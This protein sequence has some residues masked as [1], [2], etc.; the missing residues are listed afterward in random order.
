MAPAIGA[1]ALL[2]HIHIEVCPLLSYILFLVLIF[3]YL[4]SNM[5][6]FIGAKS[7]SSNSSFGVPASGASAQLL[8][9]RMRYVNI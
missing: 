9:V 4:V 5:F 7:R 8:Y 3:S 1:L 6:S 2:L